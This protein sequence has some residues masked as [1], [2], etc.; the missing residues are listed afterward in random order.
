LGKPHLRRI[1]L[2]NS[3][4]AAPGFGKKVLCLLL[5]RLLLQQHKRKAARD[6]QGLI[7]FLFPYFGFFVYECGDSCGSMVFL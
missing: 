1:K 7:V 6:N 2:N 5:F 3:E 4:G